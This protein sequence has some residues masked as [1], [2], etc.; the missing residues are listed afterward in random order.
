MIHLRL[1][2]G[3]NKAALTAWLS[4]AG[5]VLLLAVYGVVTA[6]ANPNS[7]KKYEP[8]HKLNP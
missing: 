4:I 2:T 3:K 8:N 6:M 7:R 1:I 5:L